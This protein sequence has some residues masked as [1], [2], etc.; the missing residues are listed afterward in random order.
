MLRWKQEKT[1]DALFFPPKSAAWTSDGYDFNSV[2]LVTTRLSARYDRSLSAITT[3]I[4]LT[5]LFRSIGALIFGVLADAF[6]RKWPMCA[7]L[8]I[9]AVL[10]VG[11]AF[12][13]D[14]GAFIGVR[15]LFGVAMGGIWGMS[16]AIALE[17]MPVEARGLFSGILQ[18]GYS[19]GYLIAAVMNLAVVPISSEGYKAIFHIGAGLT[20]AVAIL[21][22]FIPESGIYQNR[23]EEDR[24]PFKER[25]ALFIK[26]GKLAAKQYS[27]MFFYCILLSTAFNW[28]SHGTQD[29]YVTYLKTQKELSNHDAS[30]ATIIGQCGAVFGGAICG[31]YSQF[32]GRRLTV[33]AAALFGLCMIPVWTLP[34]SMGALAA[35]N[36]LIQSASNGAWGVMPVLLNEYAPPQF[37]GV[38]PGFCY[39]LGNMLSAPAAQIQTVW[40]TNWIVKG[41]P[42]YSQVM[43]IIMCIVFSAVAII[44]ACGQERLGS[45]FE[46]VKAAGAKENVENADLEMSGRKDVG[47]D[48]VDERD[49]KDEKDDRDKN[50]R[51]ETGIAE[52]DA[53]GA[54][55][56]DRKM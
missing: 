19:I 21:V 54:S 11:T 32:F 47:D 40:A 1:D 43:T 39:Q 17:N 28:M 5:L 3:S 41:K 16:A 29:M 51:I 22:M 38:F 14:Y 15:S 56:T 25:M 55:S 12:A 36:F 30:I 53:D 26:D 23:S 50:L 7:N 45:H 18:Q 34:N 49:D 48:K 46:L 35:G 9:L 2:N 42:N 37:R 10:Q 8:W 52:L 31:Y 20:A 24:P 44:T 6:G 4:T 27:Q 13:P 33:V